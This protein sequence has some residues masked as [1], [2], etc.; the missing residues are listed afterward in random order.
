[1][2]CN[3]FFLVFCYHSDHIFWHLSLAFFFFFLLFNFF[4]FPFF[5]SC[6]F[7]LFPITFALLPYPIQKI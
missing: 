3:S 4:F 6:Y 1:V 5:F 7:P 2:P